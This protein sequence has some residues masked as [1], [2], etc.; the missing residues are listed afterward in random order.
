[1]Q[2]FQGQGAGEGQWAHPLEVVIRM[3]NGGG[4]EEEFTA[5]RTLFYLC[6]GDFGM[7]DDPRLGR[8]TAELA[9]AIGGGNVL[10][11]QLG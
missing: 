5:L 11:G 7:G 1:M 2:V 6:Q 8:G 4:A 9:H 10:D 3:G